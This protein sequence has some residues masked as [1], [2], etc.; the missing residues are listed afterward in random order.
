VAGTTTLTWSP[1][2]VRDRHLA[3][4]VMNPDAAPGLAVAL[5][6]A[7]YP[8]WLNQTTW[9]LLILGTVLALLGGAALA[10]PRRSR[11][12][13]YV[14]EPSQVPEIAARLGVPPVPVVAAVPA[15]A[16]VPV[17]TA[18]PEAPVEVPGPEASVEVPGPVA[19][20]EVPGPEAPVTAPA[21]ETPAAVVAEV[22]RVV[23]IG[24]ASVPGVVLAPTGMSAA[25]EPDEPGERDEPGELEEPGELDEPGERDEAGELEEPGELDEPGERD[26]AGES[27]EP[28]EPEALERAHGPVAPEGPE[29]AHE[30]EARAEAALPV[31]VDLTWP[32][33]RPANRTAPVTVPT[34]GDLVRLLPL[35][36]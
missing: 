12:I 23:A 21:T 20:V 26:E 31:R 36:G 33:A 10:W 29:P 24:I 13:V 9:G 11:E 14:V 7:M 34:D 17:E 4:V 22:Q 2:A 35:Q 18:A 27:D 28:G 32:P 30:P 19:S 5:T 16:P 15:P 1:S 3:L 8:R 6:A 25:D